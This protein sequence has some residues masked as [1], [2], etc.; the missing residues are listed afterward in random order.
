MES[1]SLAK[2]CPAVYISNYTLLVKSVVKY[3]GETWRCDAKQKD[4][5]ERAG[6]RSSRVLV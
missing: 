4:R 3:G 1:H 6:M 2:S 5:M